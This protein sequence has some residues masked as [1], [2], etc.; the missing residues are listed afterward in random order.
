[1]S[2][3]KKPGI[4]YGLDFD[5]I[6]DLFYSEPAQFFNAIEIAKEKFFL[7]IFTEF[8]KHANETI[9]KDNPVSFK[10]EDFK[11]TKYMLAKSKFMYYV[12]VPDVCE[13]SLVWCKAYGFVFDLKIAHESEFRYFTIEKTDSTHMLCSVFPDKSKCNYG[14]ASDNIEANVDKMLKIIFRKE[15][16]A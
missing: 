12:E 6:P 5:L 11:I 7:N 16:D 13:D 14:N 2:E 8:Y 4:R 15:G 1:M 10:L 3:Q 9:F